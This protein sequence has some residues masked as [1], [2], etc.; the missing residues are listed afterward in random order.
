[1]TSK[2]NYKLTIYIGLAVTFIGFVLTGF[3]NGYREI[4]HL[5]VYSIFLILAVILIGASKRIVKIADGDKKKNNES[6]EISLPEIPGRKDRISNVPKK[7]NFFTGREDILDRLHEKL[8]SGYDFALTQAIKG[9][10]GVGK[11]QIAIEYSYRHKNEYKVIWWMIAEEPAT[12]ALQFSELADEL[13]YKGMKTIQNIPIGFGSD[14]KVQNPVVLEKIKFAKKWLTCNSSWLLVF[15]NAVDPDE[16]SK[17]IPQESTGHVIITSRESVWSGITEEESISVMTPEEAEDFLKLRLLGSKKDKREIL[18]KI[19]GYFPLALE[20]A[21]SYIINTKIKLPKYI[22]FLKNQ[23]IELL[24]DPMSIPFDYKKTIRATWS[25]S[26]ERVK[27]ESPESMEL[28]NLFAFFAPDNIPLY[29][30]EKNAKNLPESIRDIASN[31]IKLNSV[32]GLLDIYS[33]IEK[34]ENLVSVHRL[35]QNVVREMLSDDERK[36]WAEASL[37]LI[38][39]AFGL[40]FKVDDPKS[41]EKCDILISHVLE[42]CDYAEKCETFLEI[43]GGLLNEV[44]LYLKSVGQYIESKVILL[45]SLSIMEVAFELK[46][47]FIAS[48]L[49]N[50]GLVCEELGEY[51]D[52]KKYQERA[53]DIDKSIY[54]EKHGS[55]ARDLSNLGSV[56]SHLE[57]YNEA[58]KYIIEAIDIVKKVHGESH[59]F[60][61]RDLNVL[62]NVNRLLK[63]YEDSKKCH[64]KA[65]KIDKEFY[66][67]EHPF[68]ARNFNCLGALYFDIK[69]FDKAKICFESAIKIDEKVY[70]KNH[71]YYSGDTYNLGNVHEECKDYEKAIHCYKRAYEISNEYYGENHLYTRMTKESLDRIIKKIEEE[72]MHE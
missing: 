31:S 1:M 40:T 6:N 24:D 38:S 70:G 11:T 55:V 16:I 62:G 48:T 36:I 14:S 46:N 52:A 43:V 25:I 18:A 3:F 15:D 71:P 12:L 10:G 21:A 39:L 20:Q 47:E 63:E 33:L 34:K 60:M 45:K 51:D 42:A 68:M 54:G 67:K 44:G 26:F 49:S 32:A 4:H 56:L 9:A 13:G 19:L 58:K 61:A 23:G 29:I 69:E 50:L 17:F 41:W 7:N 5:V 59:P 8:K 37:V 65:L 53:L 2:E 27:D 57:F 22:E 35:M 72:N 28:M 66:G 30:I 64:K